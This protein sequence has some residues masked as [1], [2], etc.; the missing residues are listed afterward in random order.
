MWIKWSESRPEAGTRFVV[1]ADDGC[2][3]VAGMASDSGLFVD[4]EHGWELT[5]RFLDGTIWAPLPDGYK[6]FLDR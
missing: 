1:L 2:S 6:I 4:A 3:T 5:E